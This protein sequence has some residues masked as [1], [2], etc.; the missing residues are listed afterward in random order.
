MCIRDRVN[1]EY[2]GYAYFARCCFELNKID[3]YNDALDIAIKMNPKECIDA[4]KDIY[5]ENTQIE[6]YKKIK[7]IKNE[8]ISHNNSD[9]IIL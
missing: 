5:P 2:F 1:D 4:L 3:E 7:P 9:I 6:D 8:N